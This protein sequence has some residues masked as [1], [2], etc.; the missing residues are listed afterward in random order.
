MQLEHHRAELSQ[1]ARKT[2]LRPYSPA[3]GRFGRCNTMHI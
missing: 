2:A 1:I 3:L